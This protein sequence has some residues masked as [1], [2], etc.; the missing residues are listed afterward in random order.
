MIENNSLV[1][2]DFSKVNLVIGFQK[3]KVK[4]CKFGK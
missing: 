3:C 1:P 2:T 4:K